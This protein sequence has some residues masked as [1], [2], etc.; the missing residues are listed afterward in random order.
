VHSLIGKSRN[1]GESS[2]GTISIDEKGI[3]RFTP[4]EKGKHRYLTVTEQ[5]RK[6]ISDYFIELITQKPKKLDN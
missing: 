2:P 1:Y 4:D 3:T 5:Q 6:Q